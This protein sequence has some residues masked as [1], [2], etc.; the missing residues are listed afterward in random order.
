MHELSVCQGLMQQVTAIAQQHR[1]QRVDKIVLQI[2]PLSGVVPEL[3]Q[4]AFPFASAGTLAQQAQ[5]IIHSLPIRVHCQ[6]CDAETD[7]QVNR[8]LCGKCGDWHTRLVSGDEL[9]LQSVELISNNEVYNQARQDTSDRDHPGGTAIN[10][11][12]SYV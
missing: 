2:G 1:A 4:A 5:L 12:G 8:L 11:E 6:T 10:K 9:L 3:V 7:A